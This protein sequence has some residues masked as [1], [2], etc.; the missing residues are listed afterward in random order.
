M[1]GPYETE[2]AKVAAGLTFILAH[3]LDASLTATDILDAARDAYGNEDLRQLL[4]TMQIVAPQQI[5][6]AIY[7]SGSFDG[8]VAV[9]FIG[10]ALRGRLRS[11]KRP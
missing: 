2:A 4:W 7:G 1:T 5:S 11:Y 10:Y 9:E 8:A 3:D 6:K